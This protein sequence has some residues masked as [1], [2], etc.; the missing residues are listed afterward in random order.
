[1]TTIKL[2]AVFSGLILITLIMA[3]SGCVTPNPD[4][5][6]LPAIAP[7]QSAQPTLNKT[8]NG[9]APSVPTQ[10]MQKSAS[11]DLP[12]L[13]PSGNTDEK[14]VVNKVI[15]TPKIAPG[16]INEDFSD[17]LDLALVDLEDTR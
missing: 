11:S 6:K 15:N 2:F 9:N 13:P 5:T 17:D 16:D 8:G 14:M 4:K 12:P 10:T 7:A 3:V 1:M